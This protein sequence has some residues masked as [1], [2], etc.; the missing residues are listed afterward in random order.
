MKIFSAPILPGFLLLIMY[1]NTPTE[2]K[3]Y[4]VNKVTG[5]MEIDG[6]GSSALWSA[7][8]ELTDFTIPWFEDQ[9]PQATS[10]R[11]LWSDE[12]FFFLYQAED[13]D[14]VAPGEDGDKRGVL[15]SDRVELFFKANGGMDPYYCL[16]LDPRSR[17]LDYIARLYRNTDFDWSWPEGHLEIKTSIHDSGYVVEGRISMQSLKE[18]GIL[19]DGVMLTGLFRGD[20]YHTSPEETEVRWITWVRGDK[21]KPDFH[22]ESVYGKLILQN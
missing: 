9:H 12:D 5:E 6:K 22:I 11:A 10:F 7:A 14:I 18:M 8:H 19:Q 3:E 17:V 1:L 13:D 2:N 15:P 16:E 20:Y 4:L 21:D